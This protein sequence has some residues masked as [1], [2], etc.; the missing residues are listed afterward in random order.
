MV[1]VTFRLDREVKGEAMAVARANGLSLSAV[2][3]AFC[4][5]VARDGRIPLELTGG[6]DGRRDREGA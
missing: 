1:N 5:G 4:H 6:P 3:R 2:L